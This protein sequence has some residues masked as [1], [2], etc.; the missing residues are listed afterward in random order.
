MALREFVTVVSGVPRSGTSLVMQ[1]LGAGG[2][3]I[4]SDGARAPD[5]HNPRGYLELEAV[6]RTR[7]DASWVGSATGHAVKVI[8]VLVP[9]L[10]AGPSYRLVLVIRPL[11]EVVASQ[12]AMLGPSEA[13]DAG[14]TDSRLA[15]IFAAQLRE[16]ERW[17]A[18]RPEV[19]LLRIDYPGLV[20]DPR[21]GAAA[22]SRFLG[23]GLDEAAMTAAVDPAL[24]RQRRP[25][26]DGAAQPG[27]R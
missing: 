10:P 26:V 16:V 13:L 2:F 15:E 22:L 12:R 9:A 19:S 27:G 8:H 20:G 18:G 23:G 7:R 14:P 11:G 17:A 25:V 4:R 6:K 24:Y 21:P 5:A 1:M 3:P